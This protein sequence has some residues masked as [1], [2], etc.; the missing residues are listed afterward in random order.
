LGDYPE[1]RAKVK[2]KRAKGKGQRSKV[3]VRMLKDMR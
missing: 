3:G 1:F 2:G